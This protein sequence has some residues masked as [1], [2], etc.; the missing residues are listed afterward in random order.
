MKAMFLV[1]RAIVDGQTLDTAFRVWCNEAPG[2]SGFCGHYTLS[3]SHFAGNAFA[4][5]Q[6]MLDLIAADGQTE[7]SF[8]IDVDG[9]SMSY[10]D[11]WEFPPADRGKLISWGALP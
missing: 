1:G 8:P 11:L 7:F 6:A 10:S 2:L 5:D 4:D 3:Y 9:P